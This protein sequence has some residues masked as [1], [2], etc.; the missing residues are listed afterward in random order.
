MGYFRRITALC[1]SA[2]LV[3]ACCSVGFTFDANAAEIELAMSQTQNQS[4]KFSKDFTLTGNYA[5]DLI[6]VANAQMGKKQ[7]ELGYTEAWC[8]NFV[9]DCARLTQMPDN[10]IP[11]NYGMRASCYYMYNY[12]LDN[13]NAKVIDDIKDLRRGDLVFYVCPGNSF[14][15]HVG[16]VESPDYYIEGNYNKQVRHMEFNYNYTCYVHHGVNCTSDAGHVKRIYVRPNYPEPPKTGYSDT[17][18]DVHAVPTRVL[19]YKESVKNS[20]FDVSWVQAVLYKLGYLKKVTGEFDLETMEAVRAFQQKYNLDTNGD[21]DEDTVNELIKLWNEKKSPR[22]NNFSVTK[23]LYKYTDKIKLNTL[24]DNADSYEIIIK[25][26][27]GRVIKTIKD[28]SE[29]AFN[30]N[31]LGAGAYTAIVKAVNSFA[32]I[33]SQKISFTIDNPVPSS[34]ELSVMPGT[35]FVVTSFLWNK[36]DYATSYQI[37]IRRAGKTF[38]YI[39]TNVDD[40][41]SYSV[42][43]PTGDYT[44]YVVSQNIFKKAQS[45]EVSFSVKGSEPLDL[46]SEFYGNLSLASNSKLSLNDFGMLTATSSSSSQI[47]YFVRGERNSYTIKNCENGKMLTSLMGRKVGVETAKDTSAQQWYIASCGSDYMLIPADNQKKVIVSKL[48]LLGLD[49]SENS[50]NEAFTLTLTNE[51]HIDVITEFTNATCTHDG[52]VHYKCDV[53][54]RE[55]DRVIPAEGHQ[56]ITIEQRDGTVKHFCIFCG[57]SF[58]SGEP[59]E[60]PDTPDTVDQVQP[61]P[62]EIIKEPVVDTTSRIVDVLLGD[63]DQDGTLTANDALM[64]SRAYVGLEKFTSVGGII[65]DVD[66]DGEITAVDSLIVLR[67][68][69]GL[70]KEG[71]VGE[72]AN[73]T[74]RCEIRIIEDNDSDKE[75]NPKNRS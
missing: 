30:A 11:Y 69:V 57:D 43:L 22:I 50:V 64:I 61:T 55:Y 74:T 2:L 16:I 35:N 72:I 75:K 41:T 70:K 59:K 8:A 40:N 29:I 54:G 14:Y 46:G 58:I 56:Y 63:V 27:G 9:N 71:I 34:A 37:H 24:V 3:F 47:W 66:L 33:D 62:V 52:C 6:T 49:T 65:A 68:L 5:D 26:S 38:D 73:I 1:M 28:K 60:T 48:G 32:E 42:L 21:A 18:P 39:N 23:S 15:L 12:M 19:T 4:H 67:S 31:E 13:C 7:A 17:D 53:C 51:T 20:G 44:A 25:N 45:E 36:C 10:I